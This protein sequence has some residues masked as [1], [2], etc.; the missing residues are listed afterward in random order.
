MKLTATEDIDAPIG[1]VFA[2]VCDPDRLE[3]TVRQQ[4]GMVRRIPEGAMGE[5]TQWDAQLAFRGASRTVSFV[6]TAL[7][8]PNTL[9]LRGNGAA[10]DIAVDVELMVLRPGATRL[11]ITTQG[12][13]KSLPAR[14][15]LQSLKLAHEQV[16]A[17]YRQRIAEYMEEIK[18]E[19]DLS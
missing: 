1:L 8:A 5:G 13:P 15:M 7:D 3:R 6:L 17:R 11:T 12:A 2:Q 4:G 14:I 9:R 18:T 16:L 10:F 19:S